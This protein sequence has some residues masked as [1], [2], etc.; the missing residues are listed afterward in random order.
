MTRA[1]ITLCTLVAL[2]TP[3]SSRAFIG[4][5]KCKDVSLVTYEVQK[6]DT[7]MGISAEQYGTIN[8]YRDIAKHNGIKNLNII[9]V[10]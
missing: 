3:V 10:G 6:G 4:A 1:F 2:M 9:K 8:R 5:G 7:L